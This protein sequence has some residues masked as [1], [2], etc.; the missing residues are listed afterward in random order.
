[1]RCRY[2]P[3]I[4]SWSIPCPPPGRARSRA[5]GDIFRRA[6]HVEHTTHN[7]NK[8]VLKVCS[9]VVTI[10]LPMTLTLYWARQQVNERLA[11]AKA[12]EYQQKL[13]SGISTTDNRLGRFISI[14]FTLR[15]ASKVNSRQRTCA[16]VQDWI[17]RRQLL[18]L[19]AWPM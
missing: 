17:V 11:Q 13:K 4:R 9:S 16:A 19:K 5:V 12:R 14:S 3:I 6:D 15:M 2:P 10:V 8:V 7:R 1:M 18:E